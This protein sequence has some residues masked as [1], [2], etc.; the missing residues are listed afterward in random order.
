MCLQQGVQ[1]NCF[2]GSV[3]ADRA[4]DDQIGKLGRPYR[5]NVSSTERLCTIVC[6]GYKLMACV[7][8][9]VGQ[10]CRREGTEAVRYVKA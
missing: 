2:E 10:K 1:Q 4:E 6:I 3:R 9:G 5:G 8:S 7:I